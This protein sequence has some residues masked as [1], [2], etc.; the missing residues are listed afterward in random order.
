MTT[1]FVVKWKIAGTEYERTLAAAGEAE[2]IQRVMMDVASSVVAVK[3]KRPE[4]CTYFERDRCDG[5][6][7]A[8]VS[9]KASTWRVCRS[10]AQESKMLGETVTFDVGVD[11]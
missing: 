8:T 9:G 5:V 3:E 4:R 7:V 6:A 1:R 11:R 10:H 2:A